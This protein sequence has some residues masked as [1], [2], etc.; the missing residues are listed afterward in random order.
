[1]DAGSLAA[2]RASQRAD[3]DVRKSMNRERVP[4]PQERDLLSPPMHPLRL[5]AAAPV[6]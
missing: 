1:V 5:A 6:W 2:L 4:I 3:K